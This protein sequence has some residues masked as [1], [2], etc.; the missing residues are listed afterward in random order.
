MSDPERSPAVNEPP[1]PLA[2]FPP[3]RGIGGELRKDPLDRQGQP[4]I[5][6]EPGKAQR[7]RPI[8]P[9]EVGP[10]V[11]GE[12]DT[13]GG[14]ARGGKLTEGH[15]SR[16]HREIGVKHQGTDRPGSDMER[17]ASHIG[18]GPPHRLRVVTERAHD[19]IQRDRWHG[20]TR[21]SGQDRHQAGA[22]RCAEGEQDSS[23]LPV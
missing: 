22:R 11:L 13:D 9:D 14:G 21:R 23:H 4:G 15:A 2:Q 8:E 10:L 3:S 5:L 18:Q 19:D 7:S 12:A 1:G 17:G 6:C 16:G 20:S